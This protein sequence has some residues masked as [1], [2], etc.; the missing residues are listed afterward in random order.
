M[1]LA[2]GTF[3]CGFTVLLFTLVQELFYI[4]IIFFFWGLFRSAIFG[5][6]RGFIAAGAPVGKKTTRLAIVTAIIAVSSSLGA[7]PSGFIAETWG[8]K[9]VFYFSAT[10]SF[11]GGLLVLWGYRN[12]IP[13]KYKLRGRFKLKL[14]KES[15]ALTLQ[16][17]VTAF[18][19]FGLGVIVAFLPLLVT[20]R[21]GV[22]MAE[23]GILVSVR[24]L[25]AMLFSIPMGMLADRIGTRI[26]MFFG[27]LITAL[28][29]A[30]FSF[31]GSFAAFVF[32]VVLYNIGYT[33]FS[34]AALSLFSS[35]SPPDRQGTAMGFYGAICENTGIVAGSAV[36]GFIW[37]AWGGQAAFM[38]GAAASLIGAFIFILFIKL[39][40]NSCN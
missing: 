4:F 34:P 28:A 21:T 32:I 30:A 36:G 29:M 7:L 18:Q 16:C 19:F 40:V 11:L 8:F 5:P 26:M 35:S 24:G 39:N 2:V 20:G 38:S 17:L 6:S 13:V 14:N 10:V 27:L 22:S 31:A 1:P 33:A 9:T 12:T 37:S 23:V 15:K 25:V 3:L